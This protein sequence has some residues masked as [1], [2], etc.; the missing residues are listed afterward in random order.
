MKAK[1]NKHLLQNQ[2]AHRYAICVSM[3][4]GPV[5]QFGMSS[6]RKITLGWYIRRVRIS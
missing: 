3:K 5:V 1:L 2:A 4:E 6:H